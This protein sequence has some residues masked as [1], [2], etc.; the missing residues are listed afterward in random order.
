LETLIVLVSDITSI[1]RSWPTEPGRVNARI[2][3]ADDGRS[4]LQVRIDL[5]LLQMEL[6]GRPDGQQ[7]YGFATLLE[8]Q[9]DRMRRYREQGGVAEAFVLSQDECRA[10][11]EEAV[12]VYHR[13]VALF[14][15]GDFAAVA[16]DTEHNLG[17]LDLC[18]DFAA[19]EQD[20]VMLEQFRGPVIMM[21]WR[22][23]AELALKQGQ[24]KQAIAAL[25]RGLGDLRR[26][27]EDSGR[28]DE[29]ETANETELLRGMRDALVPKLPTSQRVELHERLRAAIDAENYELAAIL[30]DELRVLPD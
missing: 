25:D 22:S 11:R 16:R 30:R 24:P 18:L 14:G 21:R 13:Y 20:R 12:Q 2:I 7:P 29:F 1:L 23:E 4:L 6:S 10:L 9:R 15:L 19:S 17:I 3:T 28:M 8:Y 26:A 5:G 27:F